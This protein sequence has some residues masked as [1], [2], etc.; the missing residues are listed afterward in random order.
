V[1][2]VTT[3]PLERQIEQ[4]LKKAVSRIGGLCLKFTSP[5]CAGVPDRVVLLPGG[6]LI[7]VEI[8]R[9]GEVPRPLQMKRLLQLTA[10][11]L[12]AVWIDRYEAIEELL[13]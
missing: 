2:P 9:P 6:R 1:P 3:R 5:G 8:K 7:F 13:S 4:Q 11:G 10:L 12:S